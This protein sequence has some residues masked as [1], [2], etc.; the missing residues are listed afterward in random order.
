MISSILL[1]IILCDIRTTQSNTA[2]DDGV[3]TNFA[4]GKPTVM[5]YTI[6]NISLSNR[7]LTL[8]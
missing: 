6:I 5:A 1:D 7:S 8:L 3:P 2:C 4:V